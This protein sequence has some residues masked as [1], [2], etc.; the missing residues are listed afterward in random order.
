MQS[1]T[2]VLKN[3]GK[4]LRDNLDAANA[5]VELRTNLVHHGSFVIEGATRMTGQEMKAAVEAAN[6]ATVGQLEGARLGEVLRRAVARRS[7]QGPIKDV[8][9]LRVP[10][11]WMQ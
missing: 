10:Q 8:F 1:R 5:A 7:S 4:E 3:N 11:T 6:T 2:G 9:E